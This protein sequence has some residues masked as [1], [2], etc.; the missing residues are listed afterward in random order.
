MQRQ[1]KL[2]AAT[3][4]H[5][6]VSD[7]LHQ[8][9]YVHAD[10]PELVDLAVIG[11]GLGILRS[12]FDFV[13][14]T[15]SFWD[16]TY[17]NALQRPFLDAN[18]LAYANSIAA[19]VRNE[20]DPAWA[21]ELP[22]E[23]KRPMRKSLKYLFNTNDSFFNPATSGRALLKQ[24]Q[25]EWLEMCSD[26]LT[27]TQIIAIRHLQRDEQMID[28][29]EHVLLDNLRSTVRPVV[30]NSISAVE[31]LQLT[32]EEVARELRYL[33][34][35]RDDE[36]R[37]RA[38]IALTKLG[39][40]DRVSVDVA[41]KMVDS[42]ARHVIFAGVF[43]ISSLESLPENALQATE[44]GFV[45]ALQSCDY[46]FVGLFAAALTQ[47]LE[48]PDSHVQRLLQDEQP[49]Y[50]QIAMDAL[51]TAREHSVAGGESQKAG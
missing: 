43:A 16:S 48:N 35:N 8:H 17:W 40:L 21:S 5:H 45:R 47:C 29:Q 12:N 20:K 42:N 37:A 31:S 46:E 3:L 44:R 11:T 7:L 9:Q 14:K 27:S 13:M 30:L 23:L 19:W 25:R 28:K 4:V 51:Q 39:Q 38:M 32:S 1:P 50:L 2:T 34:E 26:S 22:G 49:E 33:V 18:T 41:A 15:G 10:F 36:I 6:V 24:S